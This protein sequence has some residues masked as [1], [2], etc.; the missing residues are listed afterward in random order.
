LNCEQQRPTGQGVVAHDPCWRRERRGLARVVAR[1]GRNVRRRVSGCM[2]SSG[3]QFET[4]V[5]R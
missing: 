5:R 2:M 4:E 3:L 1:R